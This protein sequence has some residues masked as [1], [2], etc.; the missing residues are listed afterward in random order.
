MPRPFNRLD[1]QNALAV[2]D[3]ALAQG[4]KVQK[5]VAAALVAGLKERSGGQ[6]LLVRRL[7]EYLDEDFSS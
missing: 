5:A 2:A 3:E 1:Q 6:A 7:D 4:S